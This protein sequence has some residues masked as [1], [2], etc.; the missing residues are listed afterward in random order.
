MSKHTDISNRIKKY[1][2]GELGG[3][4]MHLLEKE[5]QNDPFLMDALEGYEQAGGPQQA[6]LANIHAR[7]QQRTEPKVRRIIPWKAISI[8]ASVLVF[9]IMGVLLIQNNRVET[10]GG[11]LAFEDKV[12]PAEQDNTIPSVTN[13]NVKQQSKIVTRPAPAPK[14]YIAATKKKPGSTIYSDENKIAAN[15]APVTEQSI[16]DEKESVSLEERIVQG[17]VLNPAG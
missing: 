3:P 15:I 7:L 10:L 5:A 1:L 16:A 12:T 13:G 4:A 6:N 14:Q 9:L 2:N 8:A 11:Q 17:Y